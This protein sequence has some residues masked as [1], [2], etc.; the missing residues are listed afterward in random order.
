MHHTAF[1]ESNLL[2]NP[3]TGENQNNPDK[4]IKPQCSPPPTP[5]DTFLSDQKLRMF[6]QFL[7]QET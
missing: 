2:Q 6:S 4:Q 5:R 7:H 1:L 3:A